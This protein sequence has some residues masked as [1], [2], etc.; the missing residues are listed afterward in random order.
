MSNLVL[1]NHGKDSVPWGEKALAL[2]EVAKQQGFQFESLDY[3][4]SNDP[5]YRVQQL[6]AYDLAHV[7]NLYLVGSSMGGYVA[8]VAAETLKPK[9]LFLIAPAFYLQGYSQTEFNPGTQNIIVFHGWQDDVVPPVHAWRFS[10]KHHACL[11]MVDA[12][13]RLLTILPQM[14][15][16]FA[17]F[18]KHC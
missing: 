10:E 14:Q 4:T 13:H 12:D 15:E 7:E 11:H 18:L 8:T 17:V 2:A 5:D 9:G 3:T 1:Y 16:A 6:L